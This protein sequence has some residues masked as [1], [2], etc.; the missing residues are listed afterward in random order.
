MAKIRMPLVDK[1][2]ASQ[3]FLV[4]QFRPED[5]IAI[6]LAFPEKGQRKFDTLYQAEQTGERVTR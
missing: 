1:Q 5:L 3:A 2:E 6:Y 4:A